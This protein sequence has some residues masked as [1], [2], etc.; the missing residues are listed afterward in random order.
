MYVRILIQIPYIC[1][2]VLCM[3]ICI[4]VCTFVCMPICMYR[5]AENIRGI[6]FRNFTF[7]QTF[8]RF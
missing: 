1:H 2:L 4:C 6:K 8:L 7:E 5:R 3:C